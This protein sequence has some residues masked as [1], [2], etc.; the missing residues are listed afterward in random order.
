MSNKAPSN[1]IQ[2]LQGVT[3]WRRQRDQYFAETEREHSAKLR[4][5]HQQIEKLHDEISQVE[6]KQSE[7]R[8]AVSE[9]E[10]QEK[11]RRLTG[12][13]TGL[14][15]DQE[16][17]KLRT[18]FYQRLITARNQRIQAIM[19]GEEMRANVMEYEQFLEVQD[20][21]EHFPSTYQSAMLSHHKKIMQQL[22][23]LFN[24]VSE[25]LGTVEIEHETI[26]IVAALDPEEG[27]PEAIAVIL[28]VPFEVYQDLSVQDEGVEHLVAYRVVAAMSS[29]LKRCGVPDAAMYMESYRSFLSVHAWLGDSDVVA[30]VKSAFQQELDKIHKVAAE[31]RSLRLGIDVA[32]VET[33]VIITESVEDA[34]AAASASSE[35]ASE[36]SGLD[37]PEADL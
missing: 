15:E 35:S 31:L 16:C 7:T 20:Q 12:I 22:N 11:Q 3:E 36:S 1:L 24:A 4:Q 8:G 32:W 14:G 21:L 33:D 13:L 18:P 29:M 37:L 5:L 19:D 2:A 26:G 17:V 6:T 34:E 23:P 9:L 28:P 10:G 30:D 25:P 27:P